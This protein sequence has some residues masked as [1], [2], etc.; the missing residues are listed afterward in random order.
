MPVSPEN[1]AFSGYS[2][3][4]LHCTLL[5]AFSKC[6]F[7]EVCLVLLVTQVYYTVAL[8]LLVAFRTM[9]DVCVAGCI[10]AS[11][12]MGLHFAL[13]PHVAVNIISF[14]IFIYLSYLP[15]R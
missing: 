14:L 12:L 15:I 3:R 4:C 1:D 10:Q 2:Y 5:I 13:S 9:L 6:A 7:L 8:L 11:S